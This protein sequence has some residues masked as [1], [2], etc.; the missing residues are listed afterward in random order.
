MAR[1]ADRSPR[2]KV[3]ALARNFGKEIALSAGVTCARGEAVVTMDADL[4][5]PPRL[6]PEF[7]AA[8][9]AGAD[10]VIATR[11]TTSDKPAP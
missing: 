10:M 5:H 8:W 11:R 9:T 7:V 2:V 4:Q 1:L 3:V 6:L